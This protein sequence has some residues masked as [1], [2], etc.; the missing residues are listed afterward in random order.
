VSGWAFL[1]RGYQ[2]GHF[3]SNN[4]EIVSKGQDWLLTR[5]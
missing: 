2:L 1:N 5:S 4:F 3:L